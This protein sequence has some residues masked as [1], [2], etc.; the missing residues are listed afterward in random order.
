MNIMKSYT[1]FTVAVLAA[2]FGLA[3]G[4]EITGKVTLK[5]TPPPERPIP[6][7]GQYEATCGKAHTG[8]A[9]KT[10]H[11]VVSPDKGLANVFVYIKEGA[12]PTPPKGE[13]P[14]LDQVGCMYEPYVLGAV[15]GQK[16]KIRNSDPFMHNVHAT[17]KKNPEFNF[18]QVVKGQ[19]NEKAFDKSE[20][21]VRM[22]CDVHEWMFAYIGVVDHPYYAV[23]AKDGSFTI[24]D[25]PAG[26]YT[27]EAFHLKAGAKNEKVKLS[28]TDK[29]TLAFELEVPAPQ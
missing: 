20:V 6:F 28:D 23:T 27:I 4:A 11:Y 24:K 16:I 13:S 26:D 15:A 18:A 7:T 12:K 17:P 19:V 25:V 2:S 1:G 10:R 14:L 22:K 5:G 8:E 3:S 21:L 9:A 29:K